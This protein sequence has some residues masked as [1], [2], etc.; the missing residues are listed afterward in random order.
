MSKSRKE[1]KNKQRGDE[2]MVII[3][4]MVINI[5][6]MLVPILLYIL[7]SNGGFKEKKSFVMVIS[8]SVAAYLCFRA[9]IQDVL[10]FLAVCSLPILLAF[11]YGGRWAGWIVGMVST[12]TCLFSYGIGC[13]S[14]FTQTLFVCFLCTTVISRFEQLQSKWLRVRFA[15]FIAFAALVSQIAIMFFSMTAGGEQV[16]LDGKVL[17]EVLLMLAVTSGIAFLLI[18]LYESMRQREQLVAHILDVERCLTLG[19]LAS[20][21]AHEIRNPL[22]VVKGCL[23]LLDEKRKRSEYH[24][25]IVNEITRAEEIIGD[26]VS[27]ASPTIE[28]RGAVLVDENV[29]SVVSLFE[30]YARRRGLSLTYQCEHGLYVE[31]VGAKLKLALASVIKNAIEATESG[32]VVTITTYLKENKQVVYEIKDNGVG[33]T[34]QQLDKIGTTYFTTKESGTGFGTM[35]S[36]KLIQEMGGQVTYESHYAEGTKV[37][38]VFPLLK[39]G[40]VSQQREEE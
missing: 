18:L 8:M 34:A 2:V 15:F 16:Q 19:E 31:A 22:T 24:D 3:E 5:F 14:M 38:I 12:V 40:E 20:S 11:F 23:E 26:Y 35:I 13:W 21:I 10:S 36:I 1:R 32:G 17:S 9:S 29:R 25:V 30:A 37:H 27:V 6:V 33:M 28:P 7:R 4:K 39:K